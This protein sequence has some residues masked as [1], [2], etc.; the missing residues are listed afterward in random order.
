MENKN[1]DEED[2]LDDLG[3]DWD[4]MK[5]ATDWCIMNKSY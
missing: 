1:M 5:K 2:K 4:L 3:S